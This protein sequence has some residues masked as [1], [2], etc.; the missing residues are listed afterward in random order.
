MEPTI[1][2]GTGDYPPH[3]AYEAAVQREMLIMARH[4]GRLTAELRIV[5][6]TLDAM[7]PSLCAGNGRE[8]IRGLLEQIDRALAEKEI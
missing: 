2:A 6:Y 1:T 3:T 7:T 4:A 5:R 8:T